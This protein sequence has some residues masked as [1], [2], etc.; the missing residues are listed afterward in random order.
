MKRAQG[1]FVWDVENHKLFD[2]ICGMGSMLL[3]HGNQLIAESIYR[4]ACQGITF[5]LS[6][7][8]ELDLVDKV[9]ECI[10]WVEKVKFL[11]TGTEACLAAIRIAR[12]S[13]GR[14]VVM[15]EGYH[16]WG[17]EFISLTPPALGI[18]C[19]YAIEKL[20]VERI[21]DTIAAVI[22]EPI[23]TDASPQRIQWLRALREKCTANGALLIFDE[24]I[25][26]FRTPK[27]TMSEYFGVRPDILCLG[28]AMGGGL[29]ISC[30]AGKTD[31]MNCGEYFVSST[32]A[33]ETCSMA[34][35]QMLI[36]LLG[37]EKFSLKELWFQ[38][39]HFKS[40]FNQMAPDLVKL[41]G[42]PSR[43]IFVGDP[44]AK[45]LLW[46]E[47]YR[48][49]ILFGASF[50]FSFAHIPFVDQIL[51]TLNDILIRIKTGSVE[52]RGKLPESPFAQRVR[53][54]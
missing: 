15:S 53:E 35:S 23:M 36:C 32:F 3:G 48:A 46:Q 17:D 25:T 27:Y 31:V 20:V 47:S 29:P 21:D 4:Q 51:N 1:P 24:I 40:K 16:G 43:S 30:V 19:Q 34:A 2:F 54:Q 6:T 37:T 52:L 39:E 8:M 50:F 12:A 38:G 18:P 49:G 13:T 26:G 45:A 44:M 28:K 41:Q 11:K 10:P 33:G 9:K 5:S 22:V 14:F 42:Y 7:P